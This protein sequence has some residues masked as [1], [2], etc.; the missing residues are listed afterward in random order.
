MRRIA[1]LQKV[2][3]GIGADTPVVVLSRP[4]NAG[5]GFFV[6]EADESMPQSNFLHDIHR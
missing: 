4:V 1:R 2:D 6:K 5:E 3:P